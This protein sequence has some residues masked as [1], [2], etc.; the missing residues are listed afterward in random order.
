MPDVRFGGVKLR[1]IPAGVDPDELP[2]E[3]DRAEERKRHGSAVSTPRRC[4]AAAGTS[5]L[6]WLLLTLVIAAAVFF[7]LRGRA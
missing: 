5:R 7:L 1:F 2:R 6:L 4:D 3:A